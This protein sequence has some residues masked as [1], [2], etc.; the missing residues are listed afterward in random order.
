[1]PVNAAAGTL[2][3]AARR[4]FRRVRHEDG[5]SQL[6]RAA[7]AS[8]RVTNAEFEAVRRL[9]ENPQTWDLIGRGTVEDLAGLIA[10]CLATDNAL[11]AESCMAAARA[12]TADCWSSLSPTLSQPCF[13]GS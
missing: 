7:G 9:L 5:L 6:V 1:L 10:A 11:D 8:A 12:I 2:A 13:S 3:G 4:W